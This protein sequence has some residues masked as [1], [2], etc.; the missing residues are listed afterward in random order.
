M[1]AHSL[2]RNRRM[3]P[4]SAHRPPDGIGRR[5]RPRLRLAINASL[6]T[7]LGQYRVRLDNLSREGAHLWRPCSERFDRCL[8][9]WL[10]FEAWGEVVW[11]R[12]GHCGI[13]FEKPIPDRWVM[14]SRKHACLPDH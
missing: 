9:R 2:G 6:I 7:T 11:S 4:D 3:K 8:L 1:L 12:E 14:E 10:D 5:Q 13:R